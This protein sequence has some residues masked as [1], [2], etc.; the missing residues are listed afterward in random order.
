M[1]EAI[2]TNDSMYHSQ[3]IQILKDDEPLGT[4][5]ILRELRK[6]EKKLID[7]KKENVN[8]INQNAELHKEKMKYKRRLEID[9]ELKKLEFI[10]GH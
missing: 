6:L 1:R 5:A 2:I 4:E 10:E 8:L 9:E 3:G 7:I